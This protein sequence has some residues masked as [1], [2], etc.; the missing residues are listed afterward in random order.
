MCV[1]PVHAASLCEFL[2]APVLLRLEGPGSLVS[3]ISIGAYNPSASFPTEFPEPCWGDGMARSQLGL[4][5]P[6]AHSVSEHWPVVALCTCSHLLWKKASPMMA[7]Q[8][9]YEYRVI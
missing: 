2:S 9:A 8:D 7:E 4:S 6:L 3:P 5:V 1:G